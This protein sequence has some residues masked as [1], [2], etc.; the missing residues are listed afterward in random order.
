MKIKTF[1]SKNVNGYCQ[2]V[3]FPQINPQEFTSFTI[4]TEPGSV[5]ESSNPSLYNHFTGLGF[6][7]ENIFITIDKPFQK[8]NNW[9]K[10][11]PK[12]QDLIF[13]QEDFDVLMKGSFLSLMASSILIYGTIVCIHKLI[14]C[15]RVHLYLHINAMQ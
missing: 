2:N 11:I 6:H 7:A 3:L 10:P 8:L 12:L 4:S 13:I 9:T 1:N 14:S 15:K 5:K